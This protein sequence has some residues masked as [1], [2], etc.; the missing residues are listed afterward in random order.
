MRLADYW[1]LAAADVDATTHR[2]NIP[3]VAC[4]TSIPCDR[5][6]HWYDYAEAWLNFPLGKVLD[7]GC[8]TGV[9][10]DRIANRCEDRWG[11][12]VDD[13][14]LEL[15]ATRTDVHPVRI[16]PGQ[17]LPFPDG[18][19]DTVVIMEVIEHVA[20]ERTILEELTRVL[21]PGGRLLLTTPHKG[22]LTF[23]DPGNFKFVAPRLHRFIHCILLRQESYYEQRFGTAR[24]NEKGMLADFTIDQSPWHR[25][26]SYDRIRALVPAAL[27]TVAW[28]AY[29]PAFRALWSLRLVLKVVTLGLVQRLPRPLQWVSCRLSR[30]QSRWGDQ[31]II[32]FEKKR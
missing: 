27:E 23:L 30:V 26:Y 6:L 7:Y 13:E 15:V 3:D 11:V 17:P 8:G 32:L 4:L 21:A 2:Y 1:A 28:A 14:K 24:K 31:L 22:L 29:Y 16:L 18:M 5:S 20:E 10:L 12:D 9:F 25:H 19:F